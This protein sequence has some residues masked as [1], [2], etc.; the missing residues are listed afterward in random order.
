PVAIHVV[1]NDRAG[2]KPIVPGTVR[3]IQP[4]SGDAVTTVTIEGEGTYTVGADGTVT[5]TPDAD[6]V[7]V[8]T[9]TYTVKDENGLESNAAA[10]AV[11]VE[12]V[13]AEI[14]PSANDD[15]ASALRGQWATHMMLSYVPP[16]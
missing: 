8:S 13:A 6:Y 5:F 16:T 7:G 12:G 4:V 14:A 10:I 3:L 15:Q 9:V 1:G 11:T 2:S